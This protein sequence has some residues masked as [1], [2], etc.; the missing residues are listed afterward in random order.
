MQ[1]INNGFYSYTSIP[2]LITFA[3]VLHYRNMELTLW[4][5]IKEHTRLFCHRLKYTFRNLTVHGPSYLVR[6]DVHFVFRFIY[7]VIYV[8]IWIIAVATIRQYYDH[9]QE[10][11]IRFTSRTDYLDWNTT[12]AS[13]TVCEVANIEK[14][15]KLSKRLDVYEE[16]KY[17]RFLTEIVFFGG[18]CYSCLSKNTNDTVISSDYSQIAATF[19]SSCKDLFLSCEW[20]GRIINCCKY[21]RPLQ[22]EFGTCYS[23]N[24]KH[25]GGL[26]K[27][28]FTTALSK[29]SEAGVLEISLSQDYE[30]FIHSPEDIPFWNMEYDRRIITPYGSEATVRFSIMDVVNEPE[31]PLIVPEVRQCR[32]PDEVPASYIAF[33]QYSYS[34]CII[35]CRIEAQL[36]LC[37]CT[38][39]LSPVQYKDRYCGLEGLKCLTKHYKILR[40][41]QV[42]GTNETGLDCDCLPS[43]TEPDYNVVSKKLVEPEFDL[44]VK[45]ARFIL[46]NIPYQRVTR[47]VARTTLDLVVAM[48]NCFGLCFGG[49]LLSIVEIIYYLCFKR[50]AFA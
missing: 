10:N 45:P 1:Y 4:G 8:Q 47:Q 14:L 36:N 3:T 5:K 34:V 13:V 19:R 15:W 30:S 27:M 49:S 18:T 7:L 32:F 50:W 12:F 23:N 11:T 25:V 29:K 42:P 26:K 44:K 20:N 22:T 48:G 6:K 21:F 9:Y 16:G 37:N 41:L 24:N 43:C 2:L 31:V 35:Q 33:Q 39:H 40:K 17:D 28:F 38:H 46:N